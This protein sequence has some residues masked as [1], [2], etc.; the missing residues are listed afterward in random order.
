MPRKKLSPPT[1]VLAENTRPDGRRHIKLNRK[2]REALMRSQRA[3]QA[4]A[5][6]LDLNEARSWASIAEEMGLSAAQLRDLTKSAEFDEAY[7]QLFAELG[8]DPCFRAAQAAVSDLLPL[9][10]QIL[11]ELLTSARTPAGVKL[12]TAERI[13]ALN[14]LENPAAAASDRQEMVRFLVEHHISLDG[15]RVP[16]PSEY[17]NA[18]ATYSGGEIVEAEYIS[19]ALLHSGDSEDAGQNTRLEDEDPSSKPPPPKDPP[20]VGSSIAPISE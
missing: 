2:E 7:N 5:L 9:S 16:V 19:P 10:I 12:K 17:Q 11:K 14:G 13:I 20:E 3:E 6:F 1:G 15:V 8:H 4:A 18:E